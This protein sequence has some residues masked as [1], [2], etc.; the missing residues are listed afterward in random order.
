M[1]CAHWSYCRVTIG[2]SKR[3]NTSIRDNHETSNVTA[4]YCLRDIDHSHN[5]DSWPNAKS[6]IVTV[7]KEMKE[8]K[9][10]NV[11]YSGE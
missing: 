5:H 8:F 2:H 10:L 6:Q 1:F 11:A 7:A 3:Y 9:I 4:P